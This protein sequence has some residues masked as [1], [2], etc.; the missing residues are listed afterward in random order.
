MRPL[1]AASLLAACSA[2]VPAPVVAPDRPVL[3]WTGTSAADANAAALPASFGGPDVTACAADPTRAYLG[4]LFANGISDPQVLWH[5]APIVPGPSAKSPTLQQPE[6][7]L[8]G[9]LTEVNDSNDD[10]LADHPF[11]TDVDGDVSPDADYLFLPFEHDRSTLLHT[12]VENRIFPRE[13]LGYTPQAGDRTL[14][15]GAWVLDCGHPPY[16]AELHPPTFLAYARSP[17]ALSTDAAV[18]V[19]PYRS[20]LWFTQDEHL[21]TALDNTSRFS[22]SGTKPFPLAMVDAVEQAVILGRQNITT[23]ALMMA[24]RF[25]SLDF[26]ACAPLP[27]PAGKHLDAS[28]RITARSGVTVTAHAFDSIGC[29]QFVAKMDSK[30]TPMPMTFATA[31]WAWQDLSDSASGQIGYSID[32]RQ[33]IIDALKN[34]GFDAANA[35]SM[36]ADHPPMIDAYAALHTRPGA[37]AASPTAIDGQADDQPFPF[38][39][40]ARVAWK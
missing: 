24:N 34:A 5:W 35:P 33:Q 31:P 28:W 9:S 38:Y 3:L 14:M 26:L 11:G 40:R 21:A 1:L 16:G 23:H 22:D 36:Q 12:E 37:D 7:S 18:V 10:V 6:F 19:V 13:A 30:Y 17:D 2:S 15:R 32:V 20:T 4:E 29:A 25:D 27:R 39:G 8:A